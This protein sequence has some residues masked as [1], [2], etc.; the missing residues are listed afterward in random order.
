MIQIV[1]FHSQFGMWK[2]KDVRTGVDRWGT[3]GTRP[4]PLFSVRGQ[5][6]NCPPPT[7]QLRKIAKPDSPLL[8]LKAATRTS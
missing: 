2:L 5:H 7:F 4:P 6:R 8:A 1:V 3:G